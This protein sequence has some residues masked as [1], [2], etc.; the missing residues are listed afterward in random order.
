MGP[1]A[2]YQAVPSSA[3]AAGSLTLVSGPHNQNV[4]TQFSGRAVSRHDLDFWYHGA[5]THSEKQTKATGL[6]MARLSICQKGVD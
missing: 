2:P 4:V 5:W 3:V 6:V 1:S